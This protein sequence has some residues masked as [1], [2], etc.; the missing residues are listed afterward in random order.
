ML[1]P[2]VAGQT[3]EERAAIGQR[4]QQVATKKFGR[5]QRVQQLLETLMDD[6]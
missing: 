2:R 6:L 1:T 5:E 3:Q 4:A